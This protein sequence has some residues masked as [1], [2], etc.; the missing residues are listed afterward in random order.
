MKKIIAA[1]DGL[2]FSESTLNYTLYI[3]KQT[4]AHLVGVFL[5][6]LVY[7]T[8]GYKEIVSYEG[9]DL[10]NAVQEWN[11]KDRYKRDESVKVFEKACQNAGI[12]FS[13]HR[14]K[15]VAHQ[16]LVHESIYADLLII[17]W[18]ETFIHSEEKIP[19]T[20]L[21]DLLTDV[22]CPVLLVPDNYHP[23]EKLIF[24][25]DGEPASVYAVKMFSYLLP[26]LKHLDTEV[27]S[28]K[29]EDL[30]LHLP[31]NRLMK[32]F[33]KRHFPKAEYHVFKG[34]AEEQI[35]SF[36][37]PRKDHF[38]VVLGAYRRGRVSRWFKPS[39]ADSLM[40]FIKRPLFIAHNK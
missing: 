20:F 13:V 14:N 34:E 29:P 37:R 5:D 31:D 18:K 35:V 25:Y 27:V 6:D 4:H 9:G 11:E 23:I 10:D 3:A 39:M 33:M 1:F 30:S 28:I 26:V 19:S 22:Q 7:H 8:Y 12:N 36:L 24:L 16:E 2:K 32:E 38:L 40:K 15:N 21:R 17:N